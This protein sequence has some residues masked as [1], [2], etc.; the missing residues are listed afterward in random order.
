MILVADSGSTKA[1]WNLVDDKGNIVKQASTIGLNPLFITTE[2]IVAE[3]SKTL[4]PALGDASITNVYF[5]GASCS[6]TERK[7]VVANGLQQL[8]AGSHVMV[9]HD[10]LAAARALCGNEPGFAAILGTGSNSCY[11]DGVDIIDNIPALG[12]IL[13]DEGSGAYIGRMLIREYIYETLPADLHEQ[14]TADYG[15]SKD[16]IFAAVYSKPLPNR[17]LAQFARFCTRHQ[18]HPHVEG[19]LTKALDDY[20]VHH[21]CRYEKHKQHPVGFVGSVAHFHS[22]I[23]KAVAEKHGVTVGKI[24]EAPIAALTLYHINQAL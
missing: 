1:D 24:I 10:M 14:F 12:F 18:S 11:Y 20:F 7:G 22:N 23:L 4:V 8:F 3:L 16:D 17:F 6:S 13:G 9:D 21:I 2:G 5:Y 15:L 19:I